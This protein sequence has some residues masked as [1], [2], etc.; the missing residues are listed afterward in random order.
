MVPAVNL[1]VSVKAA[2][3]PDDV[4]RVIYE[5]VARHHPEYLEA[6][7]DWDDGHPLSTWEAYAR[8]VPPE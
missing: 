1:V 4:P 7:D 6:P 8:D 5:H 2:G 3:R